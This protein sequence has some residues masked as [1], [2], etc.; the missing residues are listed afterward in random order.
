MNNEQISMMVEMTT[1]KM[2]KIMNEVAELR[3][4]DFND[5][6]V[7]YDEMDHALNRLDIVQTILGRN[8]AKSKINCAN[9]QC[10]H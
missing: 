7:F 5:I 3:A 4:D 2:I 6:N 10:G 1:D 9:R 8:L